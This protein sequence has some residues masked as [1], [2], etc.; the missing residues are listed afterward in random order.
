MARGKS[1]FTHSEVSNA[2]KAAT[3]AGQ[4]VQRVEIEADGKIV[5]VIAKPSESTSAERQKNEWDE[6]P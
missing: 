5:V 3:D 2:I 4:D 1:R 6:A